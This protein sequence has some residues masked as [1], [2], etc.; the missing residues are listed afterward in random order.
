MANRYYIPDDAASVGVVNLIQTIAR[1][2]RIAAATELRAL[3]LY[4]GQEGVINLLAEH[5][6]MTPGAIALQLGVRPP[7][8]TKTITRLE[9]QGFLA[10]SASEEDG[11]QV[12]V[13]L[14][15]EGANTVKKMRKALRRVEKQAIAGLKKKERKHLESVLDGVRRDLDATLKL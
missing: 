6:A 1:L 11:R 14:T 10:R 9:E 7:T 8:I 5:G 13:T 12:V 3:G 4:P 2:T 15:E